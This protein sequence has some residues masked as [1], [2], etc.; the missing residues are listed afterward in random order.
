MHDDG[1]VQVL[2]DLGVS[3]PPVVAAA[4]VV[5]AEEHRQLDRYMRGLVNHHDK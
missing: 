5:L 4:D 3:A 1:V 2:L